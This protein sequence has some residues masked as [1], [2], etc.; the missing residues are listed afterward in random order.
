MSRS[1]LVLAAATLALLTPPP[2]AITGIADSP[3]P[4]GFSQ[5]VYW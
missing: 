4:A 5:H 1:M 3:L 2:P